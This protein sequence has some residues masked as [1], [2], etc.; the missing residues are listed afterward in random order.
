MQ[1]KE[2]AAILPERFLERLKKIIPAEY[3]EEVLCSFSR[4]R[5]TAFRMNRPG[6]K[7]QEVSAALRAA[8]LETEPVPGYESGFVLRKGDRRSLQETNLYQE[9]LLYIQGISSMLVPLVLNP[10]PGESVLDLAAA[11]GSK[12]GQIALMM[13]GKGKLTVN[14]SS[15]KRFFKLKANIE[16]TGLRNIKLSLVP[17]EKLGRK[18]PEVYDRVLLDAPCSS[19]GRFYTGDPASFRY[20]KPQKVREMVRK[21]KRLLMAAFSSLKPGGVLVYSTCTFSPEENEGVV[22]WG[23]RKFGSAAL[24]EPV[25]LPAVNAIEG[26]T[27]WGRYRFE[28]GLR[29]AR[30]ILPAG[31][32]EAFFICRI[33]KK[34]SWNMREDSGFPGNRQYRRKR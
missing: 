1:E 17:G 20:W 19:E 26:L 15:R 24:P 10:L 2:V 28:E 14:D 6:L 27:Q 21:Q 29:L 18:S 33:R 25:D 31:G 12:A 16:Q 23:L 32:M 34:F 8:G 13:Q 7:S 4:E 9:G 22:D 11:P 30:R 3:Y 5:L